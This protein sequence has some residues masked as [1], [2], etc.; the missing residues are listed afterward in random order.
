MEHMTNYSIRHGEAVAVGMA[1]DLVYAHKIGL[2]AQ[3]VLESILKVIE[4]VGF[5]LK[6]P[7]PEHQIDD[8]I[9][10][11]E[12]FREHLG[13]KLTITLISEI[14]KKLDVH[15]IDTVKMKEAVSSFLHTKPL[16]HVN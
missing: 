9:N 16:S 13:G 14:G 11:I 12:E 6:L 2:I 1:I 4:S 7:I 15:E 5:D 10:G 8:L 3:D